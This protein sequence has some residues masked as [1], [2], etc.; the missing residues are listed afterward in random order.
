[1]QL[2]GSTISE[3]FDNAI[4]N[5]QN[6]LKEAGLGLN[7]IVS[8]KLY[9]TDLSELKELNQIYGNYFKHPLPTRTAVEVS[10]LPLGR[11][12]RLTSFRIESNNSY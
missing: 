11:V 9:L 3:K 6:I 4:I 12:W 2:I 5:V 8:V 1:M 10:K 7:D